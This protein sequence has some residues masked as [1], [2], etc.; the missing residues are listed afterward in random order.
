MTGHGD[1]QHI[2]AV[3]VANNFFHTLGV[4]PAL[5]RTFLPDEHKKGAAPVAMLTYPFWQQQFAGDPNVLGKTVDFDNQ[6]VTIIGVLP[7]PSISLPSF[8]PAFASISSSPLISIKF[9]IGATRSPSSAASNKMFLLPERKPKLIS[10]LRN[11][12]PRIPIRTGSWNIPPT[13]PT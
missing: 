12:V 10:S 6:S 8:L 7:N 9:A 2:Q 3:M 4:T 13:S 1:P 11:F 5:G